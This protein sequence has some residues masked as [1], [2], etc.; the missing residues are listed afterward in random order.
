MIAMK[1]DKCGNDDA[2]VDY[3]GDSVDVSE[4]R[5]MSSPAPIV[6]IIPIKSSTDVLILTCKMCGYKWMKEPLTLSN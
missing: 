6:T 5:S 2:T 1:C 4:L 3:Y